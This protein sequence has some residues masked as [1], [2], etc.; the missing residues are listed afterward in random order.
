M[1]FFS[2]PC[3]T[4]SAS[5]LDA[6]V[7]GLQWC[8][9]LKTKHEWPWKG[10]RAAKQIFFTISSL[11]L[12]PT[13]STA[14]SAHL[15]YISALARS[16]PLYGI[17]VCHTFPPPQHSSFPLVKGQGVSLTGF[18]AIW[19][20]AAFILRMFCQSINTTAPGRPHAKEFSEPQLLPQAQP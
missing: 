2:M 8:N 10:V 3:S 1:H 17:V 15:T 9:S 11:P 7:G 4:L 14:R 6:Y 5:C 13:S 16:F 18:G 20:R 19:L 12:Y